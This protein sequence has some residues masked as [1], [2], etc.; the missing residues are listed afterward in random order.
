[1]LETIKNKIILFI[2]FILATVFIGSFLISYNFLEQGQK[3]LQNDQLQG[4][5]DLASRSFMSSYQNYFESDKAKFK[6]DANRLVAGNDNIKSI[7]L[8][9]IN[10]EII[11]DTADAENQLRPQIS[12]KKLIEDI[13]NPDV[14]FEY[15][16]TK[17]T[18]LTYIVYPI[19]KEFGVH[20]QTLIYEISYQNYVNRLYSILDNSFLYVASFYLG[21]FLFGIFGLYLLLFPITVLE[22]GVQ[23]I[24]Q[25][26]LDYKIRVDQ[27]GD[28]K[29]IALAFNRMAYNLKY[30]LQRSE[31]VGLLEKE[32]Q[33]GKA[34]LD[35]RF[36]DLQGKTAR[37]E[38]LRG[39][40][41]NL[42][43]DANSAKTE[44]LQERD[45][46]MAII[47]NFA[48]G[49]VTLDKNNVITLINPLGEE[50][51]EVKFADI[52]NHTLQE[53][54]STNPMIAKMMAVIGNIDKELYREELPLRE[55][56]ILEVSVV[57]VKKG[58]EDVSEKLVVIH[59]ITREK[60]VDQTKSEFISIAAHQLR[61]P[62]SAIKWI[63]RMMSDGD[64][65]QVSKEQKEYLNKGYT[66]TERLVKVVNDL[67]NVSRI[68]QGRFVA[69]LM[70]ESI[71]DIMKEIFAQYQGLSEERKIKLVFNDYPEILPKLSVDK[72]KIKIAIENLTE[73]AINY[74][75]KEGSVILALSKDG[76]NILISV[77][78]TGI[79]I[80]KA[81]QERIFTKFFRSG[82]AL[83]VQTEGSGMGL[84]VTKNIVEAHKGRVWFE[85][86]EGKGTTFY[87]SLP[88]S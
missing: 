41:L 43:E 85:S 37:M 49:I 26:N 23:A 87:I 58:G 60:M 25:G 36:K 40:L 11:F 44:A 29:N 4:Y 59:D 32:L 8:A 45:K 78:D 65:G 62:L 61:T 81:E 64:W 66:S 77:K 15:A 79:G 57:F 17:N 82:N 27:E 39:A 69:N 70:P 33:E 7:K 50:L 47:N 31:K 24:N 67:L 56:Q 74:T 16:D 20:E 54:A 55:K 68:E 38:E 84:F 10:G 88:I 21:V 76:N 48:D 1:M 35:R 53:L 75:P 86:F 52:A 9:N 46:T 28:I 2:L 13:R 83:R 73:N 34:E 51:L 63:F 5:V 14:S 80:P 42:T 6:D 19:L 72:E 3:E 22:K 30:S 12:D 18:N 71:Q